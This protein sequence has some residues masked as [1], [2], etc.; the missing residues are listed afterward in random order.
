MA[1]LSILLVPTG[2]HDSIGVETV[3]RIANDDALRGREATVVE[4]P[5]PAVGGVH[6]VRRG[7]R[8]RGIGGRCR[9]GIRGGLRGRRRID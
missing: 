5:L 1:P 9:L 8:G 2:D 7:C 6:P 4:L 3:G